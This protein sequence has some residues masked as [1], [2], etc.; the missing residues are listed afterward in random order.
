MGDHRRKRRGQVAVEAALILPLLIFLAL[1]II[2]LT[3]MQHAKIMTEYAAFSG[4]RAG[5]VWNGNNQRMRDAALFALLPTAGRT[6]DLPHLAASAARQRATDLA[7]RKLPWSG[8]S[9]EQIHGSPLR[10][11]VRVDVLNPTEASFQSV[12]RALQARLPLEEI[13]FDQTESEAIRDA[14]VLTIRLRYW[15]ELR[16]P[17]ANWLL[18]VCWYAAHSAA[19]LGGSI[20]R[21]ELAA[22]PGQA[23]AGESLSGPAVATPFGYPVAD[24]DEMRILWRLATGRLATASRVGPRFYIPLDAVYSMRMQ[25]NFYRKWLMHAGP[26]SWQ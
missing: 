16:I 26:S 24:T 15:Y 6:D 8:T 17:L 25:S 4:A 11:L 12:Q 1:G 7:I 14:G 5:I 22:H 3:A 23:I 13:D 21:P 2:Q 10:G 20:D 9:P 19:D 18:F